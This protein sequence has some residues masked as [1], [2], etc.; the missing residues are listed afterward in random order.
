MFKLTQSLTAEITFHVT[1]DFQIHIRQHRLL[2]FSSPFPLDHFQIDKPHTAVCGEGPRE[3]KRED[4]CFPHVL[5]KW[6]MELLF[7]CCRSQSSTQGDP[8]KYYRSSLKIS[9]W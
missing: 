7:K 1:C 4:K 9:K 2:Q 3:N 6:L 5:G 8:G